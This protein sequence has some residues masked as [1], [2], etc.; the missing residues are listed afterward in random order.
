M[1]SLLSLHLPFFL[2]CLLTKWMLS[3]TPAMFSEETWAVPVKKS[4]ALGNSISV[5]QRCGKLQ[6][7]LR[8]IRQAEGMKLGLAHLCEN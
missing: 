5:T 8:G 1:V 3:G 7:L 2:K 4:A 6:G